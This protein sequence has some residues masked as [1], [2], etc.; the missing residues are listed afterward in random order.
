MTNVQNS[1]S[2][3]PWGRR[4]SSPRGQSGSG[5]R[6]R[7]HYRILGLVGRGQFG[8]VFFGIHRKTGY[9]Y[10]LKELDHDRF[11]THQFL[12]E[13]RFLV[14]LQH[15]NIVTCWACE[16]VGSHR[17][18]VTDY[19]EGGT[20]RQMM[21][22]SGAVAVAQGL[23]LVAGILAGLEHAHDQ[24]IIHCDIKP[25]NIL[26]N[27]QGDWLIP[28]IA[29]FGIARLSQELARGE[30]VSSG[31]S[32]SPAYMAPERFYGQH[33]VSADLYAV[34]V[35][36]YELMLGTR[37]FSGTPGALMS[38]HLKQSV[39]LPHHLPES[40]REILLRSLAKL[41]GQRY[42]TAKEMLLA[43]RSLMVEVDCLQFQD[44]QCRSMPLV[45]GGALEIQCGVLM[46]LP[47]CSSERLEWPLQGL[48]VQYRSLQGSLQAPVLYRVEAEQVQFGL[49]LAMDISR[50]RTGTHGFQHSIAAV[51]ETRSGCYVATATGLH[52]CD[53]DW[54]KTCLNQLPN[55]ASIAVDPMGNWFTHGDAQSLKMYC[56]E[57]NEA[58]W[59]Q[60]TTPTRDAA[61]SWVRSLDSNHF[62]VLSSEQVRS[63]DEVGAQTGEIDAVLRLDLWARRGLQ[64]GSFQ[65]PGN[66][67]HLWEMANSASSYQLVA[68]EKSGDLLLISLKPLRVR[69]LRLPL[70]PQVIVAVGGGY[71]AIGESGRGLVLDSNGECLGAVQVPEYPTSAVVVNSDDRTYLVLATWNRGQGS[72]S[73]LDLKSVLALF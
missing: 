48:L 19:C 45:E 8:R 52:Y 10:A 69:R 43:V 25:E 35:I 4:S 39:S 67:E 44:A 1:G 66:V 68:T 49:F 13:L 60:S 26:I 53:E 24:G 7:S 37:P 56:P 21:E 38:A 11:P 18:L 51:W 40:L 63:S 16:Y 73:V 30:T 65:I 50:S 55:V 14:M 32:G 5:I 42:H 33:S 3:S 72:L 29:D 27:L 28:R 6:V 59:S 70:V 64:L 71:V 57:Q 9:L 34:G 22:R 15:P 2:S 61:K 23:E 62:V 12:R 58:R 36:L 47:L 17:Y 20:L 41:S 46:A 54:R 31:M